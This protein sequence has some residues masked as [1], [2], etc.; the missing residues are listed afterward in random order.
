MSY[1]GGKQRLATRILAL[2]P[3]HTVYVEPFAGGASLLFAKPRPVVTDK[4][5]YREVLN[6]HDERLI[7]VY[8]V[9][10]DPVSAAALQHRLRYTPYSRA[11]HA[12]ALEICRHTWATTD[13]VLRA[14]AVL[15]NLQQSF[16]HQLNAGW[17][18]SV[19]NRNH[20]ATWQGW[21]ANLD[22]LMA[23]LLGVHLECDDALA[24]IRRWDSPQ[25]LFYCD[26]PY[27]DTDQGHYTGWTAA[28]QYALLQLLSEIEGSVV[29]SGYDPAGVPVTWDHVT[30]T[31]Y[32][33]AS[34]QGKTGRQDRSR[35]AHPQALGDRRRI[36]H[37][38]RIDRSAQMRPEL[39]RLF[40]GH[41]SLLPFGEDNHLRGSGHADA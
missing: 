14:W 26:P 38:W 18:T 35:A 32:C 3:P 5:H 6:D 2:F 19:F 20:A 4:T 37:V 13:D 27:V 9:C 11:E 30:W 39:Q 8:R 29:L 22:Q 33:S 10:Q 34:G 15:V 28:H 24:V 40:V 36:E 25:T 41:Q 17:G 16:A 7:T 31:S 21:Q 12:K 1:Y 23:R